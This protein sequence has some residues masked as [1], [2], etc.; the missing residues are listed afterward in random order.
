M[1]IDRF[2]TRD[3]PAGA[4]RGVGCPRT[5]RRRS[6]FRGARRSFQVQPTVS[7]RG[8]AG[9]EQDTRCLNAA[10]SVRRQ[11]SELL[12]LLVTGGQDRDGRAES[13]I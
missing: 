13:Q 3:L 8:G 10:T 12:C 2:P 7:E 9:A 11:R 6:S 4:V 1:T 5:S